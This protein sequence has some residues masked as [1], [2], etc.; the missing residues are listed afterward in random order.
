MVS[1]NTIIIGGHLGAAPE[2]RHAASGKQVCH[3]TVAT[4]RWD[5]KTQAEVADWHH[6]IVFE[7]QAEACLKY[8]QKGSAVIVEGRLTTNQWVGA[9]GKKNTRYEI[10]ANR[11]NFLGSSKGTDGRG[12]PGHGPRSGS[13]FASQEPPGFSP[14]A[15]P[16]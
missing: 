4:N 9:D 15:V 2:D 6:V 7:R 11:V 14:E 16:F 8:L 3:F 1:I 13:G 12:E 5:A 10:L